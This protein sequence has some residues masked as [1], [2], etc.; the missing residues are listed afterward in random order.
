MPTYS[1]ELLAKLRLLDSKQDLLT[2]GSGINI[3][4]QTD[5]ISGT[6]V[7]PI[8]NR[9]AKIATVTNPNGISSDLYSPNTQIT[10]M[11]QAQYDALPYADKVNGTAYF[12][13]DIPDIQVWIGTEIEY[14]NLPLAT[15]SKNNILFFIREDM[16]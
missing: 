9:G 16:V 13:T 4:S 1:K 10:E 2:A 11:T 6:T 14:N 8:L 3:N 7:T 12:I 15:K 5:T